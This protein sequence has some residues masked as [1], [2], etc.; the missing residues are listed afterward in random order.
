MEPRIDEST[1]QVREF[2]CGC[3]D[4]AAERTGPTSAPMTL[5]R[6]ALVRRH[7]VGACPTR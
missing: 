2:V 4:T 7:L 5:E 3:C 6:D 1:S